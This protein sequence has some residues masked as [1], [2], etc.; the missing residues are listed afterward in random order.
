MFIEFYDRTISDERLI[1]CMNMTV[2]PQI[3]AVIEFR[4]D[5]ESWGV[6]EVLRIKHDVKL[7][8]IQGGS[9]Y[10][11]DVIATKCCVAAIANIA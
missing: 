10:R 6:F 1:G 4:R 11:T 8:Q 7:L 9:Y 2:V 3:G 5:E